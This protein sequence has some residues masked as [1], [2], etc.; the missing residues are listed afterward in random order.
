MAERSKVA[1]SS[2]I[3]RKVSSDMAW[4]S[5]LITLLG[6]KAHLA[7]QALVVSMATRRGI[8]RLLPPPRRSSGD[9]THA[10]LAAFCAT[11]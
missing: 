7:L 5:R 9:V 10:R 8:S 6:Q 11:G 1:Q 2:T 4:W 3:L